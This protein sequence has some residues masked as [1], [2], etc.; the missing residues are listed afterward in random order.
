MDK[1]TKE[2]IRRLVD[3][4]STDICEVYQDRLSDLE[5]EYLDEDGYPDEENEEF[6]ERKE[7]LDEKF[8]YLLTRDSMFDYKG[9]IS[10]QIKTILASAEKLEI[11]HSYYPDLS[12]E[13]NELEKFL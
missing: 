10:S 4:I 9:D 3:S 8:D 12:A 2:K 5:S 1:K 6:L 11:N 13:L 7:N